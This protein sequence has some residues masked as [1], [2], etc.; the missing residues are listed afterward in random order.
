[1]EMLEVEVG[2]DDAGKE[3]EGAVGQG[4]GEGDRWHG[5]EA[6]QG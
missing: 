5:L 2:D 4:E 6:F 3:D 1:M